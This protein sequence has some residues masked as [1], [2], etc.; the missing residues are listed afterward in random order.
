MNT[1]ETDV[2]LRAAGLGAIAGLRTFTAP[3]L[4]SYEMSRSNRQEAVASSLGSP[5]VAAVLGVL[6]VGELVADKTPWVPNRTDPLGLIGRAG[7]G[8]FVGATICR[9]KGRSTVAGAFIGAAAAIAATF[10]G[11]HLRRA[12]V[13]EL[14]LPDTVVALIEDAVAVGGGTSL[15]RE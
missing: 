2:Y 12:A 5:T 9:A 8:A 13:R 4:L 11:Y 1:S 15:L 6:A 7:S 14:G 3:A 10:A